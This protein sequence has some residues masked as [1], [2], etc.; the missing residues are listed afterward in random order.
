[1]LRRRLN[2]GAQKGAQPW[3]RAGDG[4]HGRFSPGEESTILLPALNHFSL[5]NLFPPEAQCSV[6]SMVKI[7][8]NFTLH[9]DCVY[10]NA[11]FVHCERKCESCHALEN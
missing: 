4:T 2:P 1:M 5:D 8:R 10:S 11:I 3:F 6:R 9:P 7:S